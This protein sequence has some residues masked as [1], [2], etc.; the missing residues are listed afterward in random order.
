M[1]RPDIFNSNIDIVFIQYAIIHD[2]NQF[3][4]RFVMVRVRVRVRV[5]Q[6]NTKLSFLK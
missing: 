3:L 2:V 1:V 5:R 4:S 6:P